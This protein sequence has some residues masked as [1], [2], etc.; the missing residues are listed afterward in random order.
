[1]SFNKIA[2]VYDNTLR[3]ETTG[4][5]CKRALDRIV[6][7][8]HFLPGDW[9]NIPRDEFDLFINIDDGLKYR[10]PEDL[11]P[12]VYWVI[13]THIDFTWS[14]EKSHKFDVVFAAQKDGAEKLRANGIESATWLPL[15]CDPGIH[16]KHGLPKMFDVSFVGNLFPGPRSELLQSIQQNF[17]DVKIARAFF[18]EMARTFS[19]S[20]I[21]FNRSIEND[22]NMRVFEALSCGSLLITNEI[23]DNGQS[24]FFQDGIHFA[25]YKEEAELIEKIRFYLEHEDEREKIGN[26]G[27]EEV[28]E[29]H[30]YSL[31]MQ[32][33]LQVT[34]EFLTKR[35]PQRSS[36]AGTLPASAETD[37]ATTKEKDKQYFE[38]PRPE[39]LELVPEDARR[40]LDV[41][42]G[43][44][45]LGASIKQ[46]QSA[47]VWG[48]EADEDAASL[49]EVRLDRV[50]VGNV[51]ALMGKLPDKQF[52]CIIF[53][54]VLEHLQNPDEVLRKAKK[55]L[56]ETGIVVASIPNVRN[57]SVVKSLLAGN[58][59]YE[60][61]GLL[62]ETHLHFFT[63]RDVE[64]LFRQADLHIENLQFVPDHAHQDW[65]ANDRPESIGFGDYSYS[66]INAEDAQEFFVYQFLVTASVTPRIVEN[67]S[68][69][70]ETSQTQ[71]HT[72]NIPTT[73]CAPFSDWTF[74]RKCWETIRPLLKPGMKTLECGSGLS[75]LLFEAV[76]CDHLAL[77]HDS[78]HASPSECVLLL[79]LRGNPR[80]YDWKPSERYDLILI[81]GPPGYIGRHG[82]LT[83]LE[84]CLHEETILVVDDTNRSEERQLADKIADRFGYEFEFHNSSKRQFAVG[85]RVVPTN[86]QI[87][88]DL[89]L[90]V[91]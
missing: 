28:V 12:S 20:K 21:V 17:S 65:V 63:R 60:S 46:R 8:E 91:G 67:R 84:D 48:I 47:E 2:L 86:S 9:E 57:H 89:A 41:G 64:E 79:P 51:E 85:R 37:S 61:A 3:P 32:Q 13:D 25:T 55:W 66:A 69:K 82:I 81:D 42:C 10:W 74:S 52:D 36:D 30:S 90:G 22:L 23:E 76:G 62:D 11:H 26:Q 6:P 16:R 75:T 15:A 40:I 71:Q 68:S 5:Y 43:A 72:E 4:G 78:R 1:M 34:E 77:E 39:I 33:L 87:E 80:W 19:A 70:D 58:W 49:A 54:D 14:L 45:A 53:G 56:S 31:R 83:V 27:R 88:N 44:G 7:T 29:K 18:D 24:E 38:F 73:E 35:K 50:L 59:T